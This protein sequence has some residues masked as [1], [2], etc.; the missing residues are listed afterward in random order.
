MTEDAFMFTFI[1]LSTYRYNTG[2]YCFA[3]ARV[4]VNILATSSRILSGPDACY[5][6]TA[7]PDDPT[8]QR[9]NDRSS[10][11]DGT[12][13]GS[14]AWLPAWLPACQACMHVF[15]PGKKKASCV[16]YRNRTTIRYRSREG[17]ANPSDRST[18][19]LNTWIRY[20]TVLYRKRRSF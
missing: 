1:H 3:N 20:C 8:I 7:R 2:R 15:D 18:A 9:S 16:Q 19:Q 10:V 6:S 11:A 14:P 17:R 4:F 5:A 12:A 13:H